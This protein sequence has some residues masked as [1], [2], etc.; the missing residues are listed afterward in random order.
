MNKCKDFVRNNLIRDFDELIFF[1]IGNQKEGEYF[2]FSLMDFL[3]K[4]AINAFKNISQIFPFFDENGKLIRDMHLYENSEY[5]DLWEKW[6]LLENFFYIY[7]IQKPDEI[8]QNYP[9]MNNLSFLDGHIFL[10][11]LRELIE[12]GDFDRVE[13]QKFLEKFVLRK[14]YNQQILRNFYSWKLYQN[15]NLKKIIKF[16]LKYKK[17]SMFDFFDKILEVEKVSK[18]IG[19][20]TNIDDFDFT[21]SGDLDEVIRFEKE[22]V[23]VIEMDEKTK[24]QWQNTIRTKSEEKIRQIATERKINFFFKN[25][26]N[27]INKLIKENFDEI[28]NIDPQ[29]IQNPDFIEVFKM[30]INP[31]F[32]KKQFRE[33]LIRYLNWDLDN[34]S[35]MRQFDTP[36]NQKWL[37]ENL[38]PEQQ[39][40][41]LDKNRAEFEIKN[42]SEELENN[43]SENIAHHIRVANDKINEINSFGFEFNN[44]DNLS[45]LEKYFNETIKKQKSQIKQKTGNN[46]FEDLEFQIKSAKEILQK[47]KNQKSPKIQKVIIEREQNPLKVMMMWNCVNWSCLSFYNNIGNYYSTVANAID[48]NKAVFYIYNQENQIIARVLATIGQ[49]RKL[50]R[51]KMYYSWWNYS[52]LNDIFNKYF[53]DLAN[54]MNIKINWDENQV[55]NIES[56]A[57][58]R[59]WEYYI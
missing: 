43:S 20:V 27:Q 42:N 52:N 47:S 6:N 36:A 11:I 9:K 19:L 22:I 14:E 26:E 40:I 38:N 13:I 54:R 28:E 44:F 34:V 5:S 55:E 49:D 18:D 50:T 41:W 57:W 39:K 23:T 16:F 33:I 2:S 12:D 46:I 10:D 8:I 1:I 48:A 51:Y 59:D 53:L 56:E 58:Y 29:K 32:N 31:R 4:Y 25:Y 15:P 30:S 3:N 37:N 24:I 17:K 35:E 21:A 45:E 7:N